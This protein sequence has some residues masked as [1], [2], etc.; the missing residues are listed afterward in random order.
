MALS[1]NVL[2]AAYMPPD[3][4]AQVVAGTAGDVSSYLNA[5][6]TAAGVGGEVWLPPGK[7]SAA[8]VAVYAGQRVRGSGSG[9]ILEQVGGAP[10]LASWEWLNGEPRIS[11][12]RTFEDFVVE[13]ADPSAGGCSILVFGYRSRIRNVRSVGLP[14]LLTSIRM[15]GSDQGDAGGHILQD[16][17]SMYSPR[18]AV[19]V[20]GEVTDVVLERYGINNCGSPGTAAIETTGTAG[21][22]IIAPKIFSC[23]GKII[24][25][26]NLWNLL[27]S[28]GDIDWNGGDGVGLD[29]SVNLPKDEGLR[30]VGTNLRI[31]APDA[32]GAPYTMVS[33]HGNVP[34]HL[35]QVGNTYWVDT[36]VSGPNVAACVLNGSRYA[37]SS[38]GNDYQGFSGMQVGNAEYLLGAATADRLLRLQPPVLETLAGEA[39]SLE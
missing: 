30:M 39:L 29:F 4:A 26:E 12:D 36:S 24:H 15:D 3:V 7:Y 2:D 21:W 38:V 11:P 10:V 37:G 5:A 9:T 1:V 35:T 25:S 34:V 17:Y 16:C 27:I 19:V 22:Q 28:G 23:T 13:T 14:I 32:S 8:N 18:G 20:T 31:R 6:T 33:I